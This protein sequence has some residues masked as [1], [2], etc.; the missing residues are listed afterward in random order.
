[1][2]K[3]YFLLYTFPN[4]REVKVYHKDDKVVISDNPQTLVN[5]AIELK[6]MNLIGTAQV[7]EAVAG[8]ML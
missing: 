1:M 7:V 5:R 2:T 4:Q 6:E 8:D 3:R